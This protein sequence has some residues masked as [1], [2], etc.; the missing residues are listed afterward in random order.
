MMRYAASGKGWRA[1]RWR[2]KA[3][4]LVVLATARSAAISS[5]VGVHWPGAEG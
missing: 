1:G 4:T 5:S 2:V 3:E